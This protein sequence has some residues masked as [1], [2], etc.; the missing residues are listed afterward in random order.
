MSNRAAER[1]RPAIV[2]QGV[3]QF[4]LSPRERCGVVKV[5]DALGAI[6]LNDDELEAAATRGDTRLASNEAA[7]PFVKPNHRRSSLSEGKSSLA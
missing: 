2:R 4:C 1:P 7:L 3:F 6:G 5:F